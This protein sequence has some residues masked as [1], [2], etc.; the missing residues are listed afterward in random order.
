MVSLKL[1]L[2]RGCP[3]S[4]FK[5]D[6]LHHSVKGILSKG[7]VHPSEVSMYWLEIP[8]PWDGVERSLLW[9]FQIPLTTNYQM[10][11]LQELHLIQNNTQICPEPAGQTAADKCLNLYLNE[12]T[13]FNKVICTPVFSKCLKETSF[14]PWHTRTHT[15]QRRKGWNAN[16]LFQILGTSLT[17][18][19]DGPRN[20]LLFPRSQNP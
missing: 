15:L 2:Y 11:Y 18:P 4:S 3:Q 6:R 13:A 1:R 8:G 17:V 5:E 10:L 7:E 12:L 19:N 9:T 16:M 14:W 20:S